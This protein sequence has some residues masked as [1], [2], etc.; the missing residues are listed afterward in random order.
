MGMLLL[1]I[2]D[3]FISMK[4]C[5]SIQRKPTNHKLQV[6]NTNYPLVMNIM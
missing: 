4:M 5:E 3:A 1:A 2:V 6:I